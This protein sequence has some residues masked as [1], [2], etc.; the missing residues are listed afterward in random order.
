[1]SN[2][3]F[4]T[5]VNAEYT[6]YV[7][8]LQSETLRKNN[9][10]VILVEGDFSG[11]DSVTLES[12]EITNQM[13]SA[14]QM[15]GKVMESWNI[16]FSNDGQKRHSIR[17]LPAE[18]ME[19]AKLYVKENGEWNRLETTRVGSY[20]IFQAVGNEVELAV[21][22]KGM[23]LL[24]LIGGIVFVVILIVACILLE[25]KKHLFS[26]GFQ[27]LKEKFGIKKLMI[28]FTACGAIVS[29]LVSIY[30]AMLPKVRI[31]TELAALSADILAEENKSMRLALTADVGSNHIELD[32]NVYILNEEDTSIFALEEGGHTIYL[33]GEVAYLE[34]GKA[35]H[36]GE[37]RSD[38]NSLLEQIGKLFEATEITRT[39]EQDK[40]I[41]S[42]STTGEDAKN[43]LAILVPSTE[44]Q[45]ATAGDTQI[46]IIASDGILQL[47]EVEGSATLK[48]AMETSIEVSAQ[49]FD[50][51]EL[52]EGEYEIPKAVTDAMKNTESASLQVMGE[53]FYR[54]LLAWVEFNKEEQV[55]TVTVLF[56]EV[57]ASVGAE[58]VF[59]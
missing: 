33:C 43:V 57:D 58:F 51:S 11:E 14:L 21:V 30:I 45:L 19:N 46:R 53:D 27:K 23:E 39:T 47:V 10:P 28:F 49:L 22:S 44:G 37:A 40:V 17:F 42:I 34:N 18:H 38:G 1:M 24:L 8:V 20:T 26:G 13:Q 9:R 12:A 54:L 15:A 2:L 48:D 4:D 32:S 5:V 55:G 29:L 41:Y 7:T 6:S 35:F 25:K 16:S 52:K 59:E 56:S 31:S 3:C 50:F 36:L